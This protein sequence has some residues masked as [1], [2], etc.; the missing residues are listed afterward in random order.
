MKTLAPL[1]VV[2]ALALA[3]AAA[4][5]GKNVT[6][7]GDL[8]CAKC[9]L[10]EADDCATVLVVEGDCDKDVYYLDARSH[11]AHHDKVCSGAKKAKVTGVV[12][13]GKGGKKVLHAKTVKVR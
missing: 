3:P 6:L 2:L 13:K 12:K 1:L 11:D 8:T 10:G 7:T 5:A 4:L 9:D